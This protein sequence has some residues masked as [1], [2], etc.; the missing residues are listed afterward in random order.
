MLTFFLIPNTKQVL[1]LVHKSIGEVM[2]HIPN[3]NKRGLKH[4]SDARNLLEAIK[5]RKAGVESSLSDHR[6]VKP[7]IR[8][9]AEAAL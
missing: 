4:S 9:M 3:G 5:F 2:P 6:D 1:K 8:Y 7:F